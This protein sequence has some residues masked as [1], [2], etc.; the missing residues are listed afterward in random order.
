MWGLRFAVCGLRFAVC[1]LRFGTI[2]LSLGSGFGFEFG[3]RVWVSVLQ[4]NLND[5]PGGEAGQR[6]RCEQLWER[7]GWGGGHDAAAM[8]SG[9]GIEKRGKM[10]GGCT[11]ASVS[12]S[13]VPGNSLAVLNAAAASAEPW[14]SGED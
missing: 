4:A 8:E 5:L 13:T 1:G 14:E 7:V 6:E 10:T 3:F 12:Q 9:T 2:G 11:C